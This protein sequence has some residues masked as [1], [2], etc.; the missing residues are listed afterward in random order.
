MVLSDHV[1]PFCQEKPL[2]KPGGFS[3]LVYWSTT[4]RKFKMLKEVTVDSFEA[5]VTKASEIKPIIVD[6]WAPWCGPCKMVA[7]VLE[8]I[9]NEVES[10]EIVKVNADENADLLELFHVTSIPTMVVFQDG[11]VVKTIIGAKPK[12]G[13]MKELAEFIN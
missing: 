8:E 12:P 1:S 13:L 11:L 7:P 6:F 10:I 9:N 5:D 3:I 2:G 4:Q